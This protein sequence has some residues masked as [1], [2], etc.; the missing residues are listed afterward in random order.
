MIVGVVI[1]GVGKKVF[2]YVFDIN[3]VLNKVEVVFGDNN[4]VVEDWLKFILINIG[5]V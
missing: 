4:K 5:L 2:D 1:V 3:E